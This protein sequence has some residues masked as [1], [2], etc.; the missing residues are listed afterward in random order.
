[1]AIATLFAAC[2]T[3]TPQEQKCEGE[4]ITRHTDIK[5]EDGRM[6]PEVLWSFGRLADAQVSPDGKKVL[7]SVSYY[8]VKEDKSN[9]EL[10]TMNIDGSDVQQITNTPQG[11]YVARWVFQL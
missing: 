8:S 10:F 7:Y 2:G 4:I 6:T 9:S 11:E 1:M 5:I 3:E